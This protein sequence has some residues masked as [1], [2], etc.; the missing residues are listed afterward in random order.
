MME[1]HNLF[2][3]LPVDERKEDHVTN[4]GKNEIGKNTLD[5][6]RTIDLH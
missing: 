5:N 2:S 3:G 1:N 6:G 4:E